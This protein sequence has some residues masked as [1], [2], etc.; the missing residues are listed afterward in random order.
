MR[1]DVNS[2][3]GFVRTFGLGRRG[4]VA[5][6][7]LGTLLTIALSVSGAAA[8]AGA[9]SLTTTFHDE[10]LVEDAQALPCSSVGEA[11][12]ISNRLACHGSRN[13]SHGEPQADGG[14]EPA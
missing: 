12:D 9:T 11:N 14:P 2:H 10:V 4:R 3:T 5:T 8:S 7:V 6:A 13:R 1:H